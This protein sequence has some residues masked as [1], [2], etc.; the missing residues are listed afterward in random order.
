MKLK[1]LELFSGIGG[2]HFALKST[3]IPYDDLIAMD[4]NT[5]ANEVYKS[6]F[7]PSSLKQRSIDSLSIA[8]LDKYK[9]NLIW[10]SPP[11][12]P[13]TRQGLQKDDEDSRSKAFLHLLNIIPNLV[14]LPEIIMLE[15]VKGFEVSRCRSALK[16]CLISKGY[17][18]QEF[19]LSPLQFGI[20][21]S[22]LRYF[23]IA[24]L[25]DFNFETKSSIWET[26]PDCMSDYLVHLQYKGLPDQVVIKPDTKNHR[27]ELMYT[28]RCKP[29]CEFL[30]ENV[31]LTK[32]GLEENRFKLFGAM[33]MRKRESK[34]TCCFTKRYSQ[35]IDGTGSLLVEG[36][37]AEEEFNYLRS[38]QDFTDDKSIELIRRLQ[39]R[40]F[41]PREVAN[42]MCFPSSFTFEETITTQQMYRLLGNSLNVHVVSIL[43]RLALL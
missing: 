14:S 11:C 24:K 2:F 35:Y 33:D 43:I 10:M 1:V 16:D 26:I 39:I 25:E 17:R 7:N 6:N 32:F 36:D 5:V 3:G 22:R 9:P 4:I 20:P 18:I 15:N 23:F 38:R 41:T 42:L 19:L 27:D 29:I 34:N 12:Q 13:F 31:D 37:L 40:F 8:E 30:E 21:N 28:T